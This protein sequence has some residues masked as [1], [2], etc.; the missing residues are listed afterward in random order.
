MTGLLTGSDIIDCLGSKFKDETVIIPRVVLKEGED[1]LLDDVTISEISARTG[2]RILL[3]G[4]KAIDLINAVV[5]G[6]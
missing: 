5:K 4:S 2:A 1:V 3:I 6:V